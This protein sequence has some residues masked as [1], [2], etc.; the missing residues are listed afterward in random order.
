MN[1]KSVVQLSTWM[2]FIMLFALIETLTMPG[3]TKSIPQLLRHVLGQLQKV[4]PGFPRGG[5]QP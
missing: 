3:T 2:L 5:R 1:E 4:N